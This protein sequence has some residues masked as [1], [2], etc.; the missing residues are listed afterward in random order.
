[1]TIYEEVVRSVDFRDRF[2]EQGDGKAVDVIIPLLHS[3]PFWKMNLFSYYREI[4]V[5]RL[6]IGN[7]GAIDG[8]DKVALG[9]PRVEML[10]HSGLKTLGKSLAELMSRVETEHFIYLQSDTFLP[11]RWFDVMWARRQEF[12]WFGCPESPLVVLSAPPNDQGGKRPLA[13][14]QFGRTSAFSGISEH[15]QDDYG[16][17]QEDFIFEDFVLK[18]G[19][20]VGKVLDTFH[21]HQITERKTIGK[22]LSVK[23]I[24]VKLNKDVDDD[25]VSS[26]QLLGFVKYCSP[27]RKT[28]WHA[29]YEELAHL[30]S[31]GKLELKQILNVAKADNHEWTRV[32]MYMYIRASFMRIVWALPRSLKKSFELVNSGRLKD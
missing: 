16:Y 18:K 13:G 1:M 5:N 14:T 17:R 3:T 31:T 2:V 8:S 26:T 11:N 20:S 30:L 10:D 32:L 12:D 7:A 21:V 15:I 19:S 27:K 28:V 24:S 22:Q 25:R 29:A 4:P 6:I 23:S 9:F